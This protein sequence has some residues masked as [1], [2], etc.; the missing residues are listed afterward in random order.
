MGARSAH[1]CGGGLGCDVETSGRSERLRDGELELPD[2]EFV[3][4][5][6]EAEFVY[7]TVTTKDGKGEVTSFEEAGSLDLETWQRVA[8]P[9]TYVDEPFLFHEAAGERF[10]QDGSSKSWYAVIREPNEAPVEPLLSRAGPPVVAQEVSEWIAS[11]SDDDWRTLSIKVSGFPDWD[12]PLVPDEGSFPLAVLIEAEADRELA[13]EERE[14]LFLELSEP[15]RST[16]GAAGGEVLDVGWSSGWVTVRVS[17]QLGSELVQREDLGKVNF[18]ELKFEPMS[19]SLKAIRAREGSDVQTY[20]NSGFYGQRSSGTAMRAAVVEG[21]RINDDSCYFGE[22]GGCGTERLK[23]IFECKFGCGSPTSKAAYDYAATGDDVQHGAMVTSL[24]GADYTQDQADGFDVCD[25]LC[26][27]PVSSCDHESNSFEGRASGMAKEVNI[28]YY[29][30]D[31][32]PYEF[33]WDDAFECAHGIGTSCTKADVISNSNGRAGT[34][35]PADLV[36]SEDELENAF[37][38]GVLVVSALGNT[39]ITTCTARSPATVPKVLA[40]NGID[41]R[42]SPYATAPVHTNLQAA[43]GGADIEMNGTVRSGALSIADLAAPSDGITYST[44]T[45]LGAPG[46][47]PDSPPRGCVDTSTG[48]GVNGTSAATPIVAGSAMVLKARWL[49]AGQTGISSPG[50]LHTLMLLM[51]DRAAE[52]GGK[53]SAGTDDLFGFGRFKAR[54]FKSGAPSSS[55]GSWD[56]RILTFTA[57]TPDQKFI[58]FGGPMSNGAELAKCVALQ[59]EDMSNKDDI[60]RFRLKA[61]VRDPNGSGQCVPGQGSVSATRTNSDFDSK[62]MVAFKDSSTDIEGECLEVE[63]DRSVLSSAGAETVTVVCGYFSEVDDEPN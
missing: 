20:W 25:P 52:G 58:A 38:D 11:G 3:T 42:N 12:I 55:P 54:L 45:L 51:G 60:S 9:W 37:D 31:G 16:T 19:L 24:L 18:G 13:L 4:T 5:E 57:S 59:H 2:L 61:R 14:S 33:A 21:F 36:A 26:S 62:K 1:C 22:N 28:D 40:V 32:S 63:V 7:W 35:D 23:K 8:R 56:W 29:D 49:D 48:P 17:P 41:L 47:D 15:V 10:E 34:C 53:K 39:T 50:R 30:M 44:R 6:A 46:S 43:R 27:S